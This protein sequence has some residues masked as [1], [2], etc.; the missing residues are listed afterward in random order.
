L[1]WTIITELNAVIK[2]GSN[3]AGDESIATFTLEADKLLLLNKP[4]NIA[5][6]R[7]K[8]FHIFSIIILD[9]II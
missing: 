5:I 3:P 4:I 1:F 2:C 9:M 6:K 8:F 7:Y